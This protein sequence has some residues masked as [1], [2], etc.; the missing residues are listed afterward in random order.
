MA[1]VGQ[2]TYQ[3]HFFNLTFTCLFA[4][5]QYNLLLWHIFFYIRYIRIRASPFS[6]TQ[7]ASPIF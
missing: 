2:R 1:D 6:E 3:G 5:Q 7:V 4:K